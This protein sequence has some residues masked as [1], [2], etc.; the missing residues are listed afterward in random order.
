MIEQIR[1][2]FR[3]IRELVANPVFIFLTIVGN[4]FILTCGWVFYFV[5]KDHN[6]AVNRFIDAV[7]WSFTTATTTGYG[8][9][10]PVTDFG[11]ILS[12]ILMITGLTLFAMFTALF[13]D[14]MLMA[15][16]RKKPK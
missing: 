4:S 3:E 8:N 13:A 14:M 11:K 6:P 9:I 1:F 15:R 5:E 10:T 7:W 12:I 2:F 16:N